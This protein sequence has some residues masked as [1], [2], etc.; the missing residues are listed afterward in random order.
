[1]DIKEM[2]KFADNSK[3]LTFDI[4]P[5]QLDEIKGLIYVVIPNKA[6]FIK[7]RGKTHDFWVALTQEIPEA[8]TLTLFKNDNTVKTKFDLIYP[9]ELVHFNFG[10]T[11]IV[12]VKAEYLD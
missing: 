5:I 6:L 9:N 7:L 1:M 11:C 2:E 8:Y 4:K 3:W 12:D 10:L